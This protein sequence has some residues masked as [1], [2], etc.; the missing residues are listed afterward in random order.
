MAARLSPFLVAAIALAGFAFGESSPPANLSDQAPSIVQLSDLDLSHVRQDWGQP[1]VNKSVGGHPLTIDGKVFDNGVGSHALAIWWIDLGGSAQ[2][3]TASVGVDDEVRATARSAKS[4]VEFEV[5]A[6]CKTLYRSGR[7]KPGDAAKSIDLDLHGLKTLVLVVQSLTR[8]VDYAHADW[9]D[10]QIAYVGNAPHSIDPPAEDKTILTPPPPDEPRINGARVF[11]VRPGHPVLY[12]IAATGQRPMS[13]GADGLPDGLSV[14]P[15]TG[16]ITGSVAQPGTYALSLTASNALGTS[17]SQL[18]L[19]VGGTI[20]LT[21]QMGWNSWNCFARDVSD[22]K[23]RAAADAMVSSGL[24]NH[25][26]TYINIDD[27]WEIPASEPADQRRGPDGRI[28]TNAK[29]PDMKALADYIHSKGLR[30][31]LYS[32]PGP[33][34]CGGFT[35]SYQFEQQDAD[36]YAD[37]GFDYLKYD[38]CSYRTV[39]RRLAAQTDPPSNLDLERHPYLVMRDALLKENRDILFS[40]CQYGEADVWTWGQA[41]GGNSWRT[42]GDISDNW[43][44]MSGIGFRQAGHEQYAGPGHWNDPDMLVVGKVGWSANLHPTNLTPN[45]Q[46]THITLWCLLDAPLLIGCDMTQLDPFTLNLLT[47]DEVLAVNQDPLGRQASRIY[48][49]DDGLE[50]WAKDM[51]DGT[52]AVGLFNRGEMPNTVM[53]KWSDLGLTGPQPV[54]DLWRQKD[55]GDFDGNY[56]VQVGRHGAALVKIGKPQS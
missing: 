42:T 12:T 9:A 8:S 1:G 40:F 55:L 4:A 36:Q 51:A 33:S 18:K 14:D 30:A 28:K 19:I 13:F 46:Y 27:C 11:G 3:F 54:R 10:A 7:M 39:M 37:W 29:F 47:N 35:A 17:H 45:E 44:S 41:A 38:L 20:A 50:V 53:V 6:D 56:A 5:V 43:S 34:T 2:R 24:V 52:K 26:W 31:G 23:V 15:Q 48:F 25:G 22:E 32:S 49:D 21:P 16:R